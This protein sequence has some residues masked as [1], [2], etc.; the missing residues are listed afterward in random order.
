MVKR[1]TGDIEDRVIKEHIDNVNEEFA[2]NILSLATA[3][4]S[5]EPLLEDNENGIY[6]NNLY[7]RKAGFIYVFAADSTITIA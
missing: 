2:Q 4:T 5:T 6:N 1:E 3:P 7:V